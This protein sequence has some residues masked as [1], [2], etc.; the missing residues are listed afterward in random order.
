MWRFGAAAL[1]LIVLPACNRSTPSSDKPEQLETV[2]VDGGVDARLT[3]EFDER[4]KQVEIDMGGVLPSDFPEAMPVFSPASVVDFGS[5]F[6]EVDT[7]VP[8]GEVRSSLGA[9]IQ[10]SGWTVDSI[11]DGGS[12]Y[13]RGGRRVR[14]V[15]TDMGS[16]SRIRYEY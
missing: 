13:S 15:L 16:G 9:L 10:R 4:A 11:G 8:A 7:P 2:D 12:V 14:V 3:T 1:L 6:V 5:G